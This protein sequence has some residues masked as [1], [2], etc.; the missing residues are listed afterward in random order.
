VRELDVARKFAEGF[1]YQDLA[2]AMHIS[3]ATVR[4][5]LKNIYAKLGIGI[6]IGDKAALANL[7]RRG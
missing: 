5:H 7:V 1:S 2:A 4:N 6:G 3:P